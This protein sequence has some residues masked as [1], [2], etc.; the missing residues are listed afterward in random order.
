MKNKTL[1]VCGKILNPA[2]SMWE[3]VGVFTSEKLAVA[4][5][6]TPWHFV[7]PQKLNVRNPDETI[8]WP[9]CYYP[10]RRVG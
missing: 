10:I 5:C 7:G 8:D 2:T 4:A 6:T 1:W 9:G 3:I